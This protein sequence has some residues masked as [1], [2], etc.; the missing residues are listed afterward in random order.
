M[1][2][3]TDAEVRRLVSYLGGRVKKAKLNEIEEELR[4]EWATEYLREPELLQW[5]PPLTDA[6]IVAE[7]DWTLRLIPHG[8]LRST[9]HG[10]SFPE[11]SQI[12]QKFLRD[13]VERGEALF[14]GHFSILGTVGNGNKQFTV[15]A[16]VDNLSLFVGTAHVVTVHPRRGNTE[17]S[18]LVDLR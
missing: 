9:Q 18:T 11:I 6:F 10:L 12:F 2:H 1:A 17:F 16:D 7:M 15:R 13:Y 4:S 3:I 14:E 5:F 8:H